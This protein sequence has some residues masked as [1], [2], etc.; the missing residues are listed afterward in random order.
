MPTSSGLSP[1]PAPARTRGLTPRAGAWRTRPLGRDLVIDG[2]R[3][4]LAGRSDVL[5]FR[6]RCMPMGRGT[7]D[8]LTAGP[9]GVTVIGALPVR[10]TT[11]TVRRTGA[12]GFAEPRGLRLLVDGRDQT[13]AAQLLERQVTAV[14][15][16][17]AEGAH[18]AL[19]V[20]PVRG[21][22]CLPDADG[23]PPFTS[24]RVHEV[25]VDGPEGAA[26]VAA[27]RGELSAEHVL[28]LARRLERAFPRR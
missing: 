9:G 28:R 6:G 12:G 23:L 25:D 16:A 21:V 4:L 22:L 27:R 14:R 15:H 19:G 1:H 18:H 8:L 26:W 11:L 2:V 3:D 20:P 7:I 10:G 13:A 24:V 17:L 5:T